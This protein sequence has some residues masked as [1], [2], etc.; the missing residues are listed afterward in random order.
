MPGMTFACFRFAAALGLA[1][2]IFAT[3]AAGPALAGAPLSA[4]FPVPRSKAELP[5]PPPPTRALLDRA[6]LTGVTGWLVVDIDTG[7]VVDAYRPGQRFVPASVAKLPTA[8]YALDR[9]GPDHRFVTRLAA[10][11][12]FSGGTLQGDLVLAGGGDPEFDSDALA[13]L[14]DRVARIG[15]TRVTG[16]LLADPGPWPEIP[17]IEPNQPADASYNPGVAGLSLNFNRVRVEW[18]GRGAAPV[19]VAHAA[20][21][22]PPT[23]AIRVEPVAPAAAPLVAADDTQG[24][25]WLLDARSLRRPGARWLPVRQPGAYVADVARGLMENRG[26]APRA[27]AVAPGSGV[28]ARSLGEHRSRPLSGI[29]ARMLYHSTNVSA[30]LVGLA[31]AAAE[32]QGAFARALAPASGVQVTARAGGTRLADNVRGVLPLSAQSLNAWAARRAGFAAGD[33]GFALTNHSGLS[34]ASRLSPERTVD[35]LRALAGPRRAGDDPLLPGGVAQLLRT[36]GVDLPEGTERLDRVRIAAKTGT[37][38]FV[39]G[40]AGYVHTPGERRLAFA[41]FSN[42]LA[43]RDGTRRGARTWMA[44]ARTL[45]RA[46][47][48]AWIQM[49]DAPP[50]KRRAS[51]MLPAGSTA[52]TPAKARAAAAIPAGHGAAP[53][54]GRSVVPIRGRGAGSAASAGPRWTVVG[55]RM[56]GSTGSLAAP[57]TGLLDPG[58]A[59]TD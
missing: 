10:R 41:V 47:L 24:E 6:R 30:E 2:A 48:A 14:I 55:P 1:A 31:A 11:G 39:R 12:S 32:P 44:R 8:A 57:G 50:P 4:P 54:A 51:G 17:S 27:V 7:A 26:I 29:L 38:T 13:A 19:V 22:R 46:L 58:T 52:D 42:D 36:Y 21:S 56:P 37:M 16:R 28:G 53:A 18:P 45:E 40:L 34:V 15:L 43:R 20:R 23:A 25:R 9:L 49:A 59:T 33:P 3:G 35:L 5:P